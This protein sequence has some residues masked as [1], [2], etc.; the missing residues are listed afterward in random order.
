MKKH[1]EVKKLRGVFEKDPGSGVWWIQYF[2]S[3]GKRH[4]EKIGTRSNA[5]SLVELR[6]TQRL[7]GRKMPKPRTRLLTFGELTDA[8]LAYTSGKA[9]HT[10]SG[11]AAHSTNLSRMKRLVSQFGNCVAEEITPEQIEEWLSSHG[12]WTQATKNRYIALLKLTFRLAEKAQKIKYNSARLVRQPKENNSRIRFLTDSE[13]AAFREVIKSEQ[14]PEFEVGLHTGMRRSE[15]YGMRWEFVDFKNR[16]I[17][18]PKSKPGDLRHV[19]MNSRVIAIMGMLKESG[20]GAG[21][22]FDRKS[23]RSWFEIA[24]KAAGVPDF[25]WHDL[26]HTFISRLVMAGVDLRTVQ[27]L[28]GHKNISMTMRYAHLTPGHQQT[29]VEKLVTLPSAS[30][31]TTATGEIDATDGGRARVH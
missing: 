11:K 3:N 21:Y 18:I 13:E 22:V 15:Q 29:A 12:E 2:D 31:T 4:R 24:R 19:R 7:E 28:A 5:Q 27:E 10:A 1:R 8:A 9:A 26:R 16:I 14:M 23:P 20:Q 17:T 6:R 25:N 30:A